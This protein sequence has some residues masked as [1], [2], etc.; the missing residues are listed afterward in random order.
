MRP[1]RVAGAVVAS[2]AIATVV[3]ACG[4]SGGSASSTATSNTLVVDTSFNL[5]TI[6]PGR[7][8][9]PTGEI[10]DH[11]LYDTLLSF[12]GGDMKK[13]VPDLA[14]SY[15]A[16]PDGK[17]YTFKLRNNAVFSDGTPVTS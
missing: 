2:L 8:F 15:T 14:E 11:A 6:D 3:A 12:Q 10:I 16:S 5:K 1:H 9:E 17:T 13:P 4:S 7:M